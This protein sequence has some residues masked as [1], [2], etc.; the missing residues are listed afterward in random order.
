M[1]SKFREAPLLLL[2]PPLRSICQ[3]VTLFLF[4]YMQFFILSLHWK[5]IIC[6]LVNIVRETNPISL[7]YKQLILIG[8]KISYRKF[9]VAN[10]HG[11]LKI[12]RHRKIR[13]FASLLFNWLVLET[14]YYKHRFYDGRTRSIWWNR[15]I[16]FDYCQSSICCKY[17]S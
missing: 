7:C 11:Q 15:T 5:Y 4:M 3:S 10:F 1:F 13:I 8:M 2:D 16:C 6:I 12:L 17:N 9:E 14:F